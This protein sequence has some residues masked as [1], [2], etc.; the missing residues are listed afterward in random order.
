MKKLFSITLAI[1][2]LF[3]TTELFSKGGSFG[4]SRSTSSSSSRSTSFGG[5]R[6][7]SSYNS[8]KSTSSFGGAKSSTSSYSTQ[9]SKPTS[10][11]LTPKITN[12][13]GGSKTSTSTPKAPVTT[14]PKYA[15]PRQTSN[16]TNSNRPITNNVTVYNS[17]PVV[18][19]YVTQ[20]GAPTHIYTS[21][22]YV[23]LPRNYV[24][25]NYGRASDA[26][27]MGYITGQTSW[28]WHTPFH[29]AFYYS[30]PQ[31]ISNPDGTKT[32]L[33]PDFSY[34]TIVFTLVIFGGMV[35]LIIWWV[36]RK[37][38]SNGSFE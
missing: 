6:S 24:V 28:Y 16:L 20:Y 13:F 38:E 25:Y 3:S 11:Y 26:Y 22:S 23:G 17:H 2:I 5:S 30:Q 4:G 35:G 32:V 34:W 12:S 9:S 37:R 19:T 7:N 18:Q 15:I 8:P 1:L 31:I 33:P 14:P 27:M 29:P 10:Q 36:V 21:T